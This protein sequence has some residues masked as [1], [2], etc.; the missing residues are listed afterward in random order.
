M[1][2]L[3]SADVDGSTNFTQKIHKNVFVVKFHHHI[4]NPREKCIETSTNM[5]SIG[6]VICEMGFEI[7]DMIKGNE[8]DVANIDFEL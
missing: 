3:T 8:S 6:L 4:W 2:G 1:A 7:C 5:P